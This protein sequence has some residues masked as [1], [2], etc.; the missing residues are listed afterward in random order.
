MHPTSPSDWCPGNLD[1]R[2]KLIHFDY[3]SQEVNILMQ[4]IK[5]KKGR[6][7][8]GLFQPLLGQWRAEA[9][10]DMGPVICLR[11]FQSVLEGAYIQ[12]TADWEYGSGG[13]KEMALIGVGPE[14]DIQFW[15]F[16]SDKKQSQ[17]KLSDVIDIHDQAIGF[18]AHMPAGLARQAYWPAETGGFYWAVESKTK[19]GWNRFTEHHYLPVSS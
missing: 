14:G 1:Q 6:G 17:G 19:K 11:T 8:L 16:T 5:W 2:N 9:E 15:S 4:K 10:S 13:Y 12:L 18:E 7:K 3:K